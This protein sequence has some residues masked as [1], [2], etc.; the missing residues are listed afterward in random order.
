M[1]SDINNPFVSHYFFVHNALKGVEPAPNP[2]SWMGAK[3]L[4]VCYASAKTWTE[5]TEL[6][7]VKQNV[8]KLYR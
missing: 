1:T 7:K 6:A 4:E 3:K 5:M 8:S 2:Q